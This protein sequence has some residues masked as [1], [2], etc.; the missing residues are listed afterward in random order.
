[1]SRCLGT[2]VIAVGNLVQVHVLRDEVREL[3]GIAAIAHHG[4]HVEVREAVYF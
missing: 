4:H 1:M 3:N 2:Q